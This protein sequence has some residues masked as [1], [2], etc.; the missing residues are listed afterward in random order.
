MT[1][2]I[3]RPFT[4]FWPLLLALAGVGMLAY[5]GW[6]WTTQEPAEEETDVAVAPTVEP[7]P[8][9]HFHEV[10]AH[11]VP[12]HQEFKGRVD[13]EG[14][15]EIRAPQGMRVPVMRIHKEAGE[16]VEKGDVVITLNKEQVDDAIEEARADG[17]T[18]DLA[19]FESYLEHVELE[20]PVDGQVLE[21]FTELGQVPFDVGIPLMT[22]AD[23][24]SWSFKVMLPEE[25]M[26]S[27]AQ[28]GATFEIELEDDLGTV[29]G[30]VN[31]LGLSTDGRIESLSG[32]VQ[33]VMGL[34]EHEGVEKDLV[35]I[36]RIPVSVQTAA[37]VPKKAVE[38]RGETPVVRVAEG[39]EF[40]EKSLRID[41]EVGEDYVVLYGVGVGEFVVVPG[42]SQ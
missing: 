18:A 28:M 32:Y 5:S 1:R 24:S 2:P 11:E 17:R 12:V 39:D 10:R 16:F 4:R 7:P 27:S 30:T 21:I 31:S 35:G 36:V 9:H 3:T 29:T 25:V 26:Q 14:T 34:E 13:A 23:R 38:W 41:G 33:V 8:A 37:L 6:R 19:R 20:A 42:S 15:V 40:L 22:L